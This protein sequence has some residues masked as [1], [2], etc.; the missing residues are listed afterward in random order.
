MGVA[1]VYFCLQ[2]LQIEEETMKISDFSIQRPVFTLVS[3][4]LV[5]ILGAVSLFNIPMKLT[6]DINPP[7]GVVVTSYPGAGPKEVLE[8]VTKPLEANLS[9]LPGLKSITST[10]QEGTNLILLQFSWSTSIDDVQNEVLQRI[11]QTTLPEDVNKPRFLKFDPR[12]Y[13]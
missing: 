8:K 4:I 7:V 10:S 12:L 13:S 9:T 2:I 11:D 6:P 3:M 1:L 5:L